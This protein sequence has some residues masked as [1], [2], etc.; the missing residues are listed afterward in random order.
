[1]FNVV[2]FQDTS[3]VLR[4]PHLGHVHVRR[5]QGLV[6]SGPGHHE[7]HADAERAEEM[8][9][10]VRNPGRSQ[11]FAGNCDNF[12]LRLVEIDLFV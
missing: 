4:S 8:S 6:Q 2:T 1:M 11:A 12:S 3:L 5:R 10:H 9:I 7:V